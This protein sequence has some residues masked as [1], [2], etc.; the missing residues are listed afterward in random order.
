VTFPYTIRVSYH[1]MT[2]LPSTVVAL[3]AAPLAACE[4]PLSLSELRALARAEARWAARGFENYAIEERQSCFCP[5]EVLQWSR[6]EVVSGNVDRVT[7]LET[8][9]EVPAAQRGQFRTV[10]QVFRTIRTGHTQD[11]VKDV[12]VE[13]DPQLGFPTLVS[14]EP[15]ADILDA[16]ITYYFRNAS[17]LP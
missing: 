7:T 1:E 8:G 5:P 16:G 4:S 13:F 15:K 12:V 17:H 14:L 3:V 6:V 11:W 9:V 10:E 2:R